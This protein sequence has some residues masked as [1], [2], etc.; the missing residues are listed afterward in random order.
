MMDEN[1][2]DAIYEFG[3]DIA[4]SS[5]EAGIRNVCTLFNSQRI[6]EKGRILSKKIQN[7]QFSDEQKEFI[8]LLVV[9]SIDVAMVSLFIDFQESMG[10]YKIVTNDKQGQP[11]DIV[12]ES[13]GLPYG[14]LEFIDEF[15]KYNTADEFLETG[16]LEKVQEGSK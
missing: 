9:D 12:T 8:K 13:D 5:R 15:S 11:F 10:K 14:Y 4:V 1:N 16:E 3:R 7:M 6:D 2:V